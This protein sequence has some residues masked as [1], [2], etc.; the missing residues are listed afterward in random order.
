MILFHLL[1]RQHG[2]Q[3]REPEADPGSDMVPHRPL[4]ARRLKLPAQEAHARMAQGRAAGLPDPELHAGLEQ[5][6]LPLGAPRL[7]QAGNDAQL[8]Q[9]QPQGRVSQPRGYI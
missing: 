5:R 3:Q 4:P 1:F 6:H 9:T 2:H 7:L 8:G